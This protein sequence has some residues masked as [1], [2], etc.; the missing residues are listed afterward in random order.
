MFT[1]ATGSEKVRRSVSLSSFE[2]PGGGVRAVQPDGADVQSDSVQAN[3]RDLSLS[4]Q[5]DSDLAFETALLH[6]EV[7]PSFVA[8]RTYPG[9]SRKSLPGFPLGGDMI[10][11]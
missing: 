5:L 9:A 2:F 11:G 3:L 1:G 10:R 4:L 7:E 6:E 8:Q